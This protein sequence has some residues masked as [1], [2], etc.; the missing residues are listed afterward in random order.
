MS[1]PGKGWRKGQTVALTAAEEETIAAGLRAGHP[2]IRIA[3]DVHR[4]P[5]TVNQVR[6]RLGIEPPQADAVPVL[7]ASRPRVIPAGLWCAPRPNQTLWLERVAAAD[8]AEALR[9]RGCMTRVLGVARAATD[10]QI[11]A[12]LVAERRTAEELA[13]LYLIAAAR[14]VR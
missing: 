3:R 14:G 12:A 8:S 2:V 7:R 9:L 13:G 5:N 6:E 10:L 1:G 11:E 4:S